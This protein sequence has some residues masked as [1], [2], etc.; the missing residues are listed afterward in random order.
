METGKMKL[1]LSVGAVALSMALAG[2][3]GGGSSGN[4]NPPPPPPDCDPGYERKAGADECTKIP[5]PPRSDMDNKDSERARAAIAEHS[6]DGNP[7][8]G[9]FVATT[10]TAARYAEG[11]EIMLGADPNTNF[12]KAGDALSAPGES[13]G[14]VFTRTV[15]GDDAGEKRV[16]VYTNIDKATDAG[17][18]SDNLDGVSA[19]VEDAGATYG[20]AT[21]ETG[22]N[23][24]N[25][26]G[27][28]VPAEVSS[29]IVG[30][31][32]GTIA[33]NAEVNG[34]LYGQPGKFSCGDTECTFTR[35]QAGVITISTG[36]I[37]FDPDAGASALTTAKGAKYA[38]LDTSY[39]SFGYWTN[40]PNDED[41]D[42]VIQ[43]FTNGAGALHED[44]TEV[45][46]KATYNGA[47]AGWYSR[48]DGDDTYSGDFTATA[49]LVATFGEGA[50]DVKAADMGVTGTISGFVSA[51]DT[52][53]AGL[54]WSLKL[55]KAEFDDDAL[56]LSDG[57]TTDGGS[58]GLGEWSATFHGNSEDNNQPSDIVGQ[59]NGSFRNGN[60]NVAGAFGAS[61]Q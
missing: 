9:D 17:W 40:T 18:R 29:D 49:S 37:T 45:I 52:A 20:N 30:T 48:V 53:L 24:R 32:S 3:G 58:G 13:M 22:L 57:G 12:K 31:R 11:A 19:I 47:A 26:R 50:D 7:P 8:P 4:P 54:G 39:V 15:T 16:V 35:N 43:T 56:T 60:G 61:H 2:C 41:E 23:A 44:S 5:P 36:T 33:A 38:T 25:I 42:V 55:N 6:T 59:F 27:T 21:L 14:Q 10:I 46:G 28:F 34:H 1:A 51:G